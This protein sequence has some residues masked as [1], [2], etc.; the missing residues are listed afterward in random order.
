MFFF[1]I[2]IVY[3]FF[4][5]LYVFG[6]VSCVVRVESLTEFFGWGGKVI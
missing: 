6:K 3:F 2:Y 5:I 1:Y 4:G